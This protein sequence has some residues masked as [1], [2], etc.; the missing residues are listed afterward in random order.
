MQ[1][2]LLPDDVLDTSALSQALD[3]GSNPV[4]LYKETLSK[5]SEAL[6]QRFREGADVRELVWMR[7]AVVD[8]VLSEAW[9]RI[10]WPDSPAASLIAVGG[11]GR[12]ELHPQSDID[13]LILI[14]REDP[15]LDSRLEKLITLFW[16]MGLH[17]GHSVRTINECISNAR[18][19][20][21]VATNLMESRLLEGK[22][23][24][25]QT[26]REQ[27][28]PAQLWP[29]TAFFRAKWD[30]QIARHRKYNDTEYNLEPNIKTCP[31][32]LRDI[33]MIG[34][35]IKR[36]FGA[37]TLRDLVEHGFITEM[38]YSTL[39]EGQAYLWRIRYALHMI[40][41]RPEDRLLFDHQ[42]KVAALLGFDADS[43]QGVEQF[44]RSYFRWAMMLSELNDQLLQHF[45][46]T[47][48]RACEPETILTLNQRFRVRNNYIEATNDRVFKTYPPALL[49]IFLLMARYDGIQG[50]RASTIRLIRSNR[51]LID[52]D[53]RA[54]PRNHQLFLEILRAQ[55]KVSEQIKRMKRYGVLGRYIPAFGQI[56]G[57]MQ[58]DLFHIYT[59]DAH[60]LLLLANLR[61]LRK[62][63]M[64]EQFPIAHGIVQRLPKIELLYL[65]ALFHDI[66]KGR[67]GDHST[68]G[69]V[70]A[71]EFCLL[72]G[73]S[74]RDTNLVAWLVEHHLM[75]SS[76]AQRK[77]ISDPDVIREFALEMGDIT[78]L[79]YLYVLTVADINATNPTLWN[80]WRDSL[81]RQLYTETKRM[82]R[83]GLEHHIDKRDWVA[84]TQNAAIGKLAI[85]GFTPEQ[86]MKL[87]GNPGDDY[88]L[89]ETANDIA[90]HTEAIAA[91]REPEKPLILIKESTDSQF[92]QAT[93]IFIYMPDRI[94]IFATVAAT[95]E[96]LDLN[97]VDARIFTSQNGYAVDTFYVLDA[98]GQPLGN[99]PARFG[100]IRQTLLD[101]LKNPEELKSLVQRY[102]PRKLKHFRMPTETILTQ[103][104]QKNCTVLEI[105]TP[106]RPG[107]LARI[108][109][110]LVEQNIRLLNA[111]ITTLGERV[112]DIFFISDADGQMI[113]D[114]AQQQ[115]L[116]A[117]IREQ[118]D[119]GA[120]RHDTGTHGAI[121]I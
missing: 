57:Q 85:K 121:R 32:G 31:G 73:L 89:R 95:M 25:F 6:N 101:A 28:G 59:V 80:A 110:I 71:R 72:H 91:H 97:I 42:R 26:M 43:N 24:L 93:Q 63:D 41:G 113:T 45:D 100:H 5:A 74:N 2:P 79:D 87:W 75:M 117:A 116:Q 20:I 33:Q 78:H 86:V 19:D 9:K 54:D 77:D 66:A 50:V 76:T 99:D 1:L 90:W 12:G 52:D 115:S 30:E 11:Y 84:D 92:Q 111:K 16:D 37:E 35:V 69:A 82:L 34:W 70:D 106:D 23:Q 112:D 107:I 96:Q 58:F 21:T 40:T 14:E 46:E 4:K 38:E 94:G 36:H 53:F 56:I 114:T 120:S 29:S 88:F 44:M 67:K 47:I 104:E 105:I 118:L 48:L 22:S 103:D 49:E 3:N 39:A 8:A 109:R 60:T 27:T 68:L 61:R 102:T 65:A 10:D 81:L 55:H 51:F 108:G 13:L 62:E 17:I 18:D 64:Q 15:S 7:A 119:A 83:R 98:D